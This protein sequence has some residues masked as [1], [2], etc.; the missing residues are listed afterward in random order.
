MGVDV[1]VWGG[2]AQFR[3]RV[4]RASEADPAQ[5]VASFRWYVP[6]LQPRIWRPSVLVTQSPVAASCMRSAGRALG[7]PLRLGFPGMALTP[8]PP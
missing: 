7:L 5:A 8:L 3:D 1:C 2:V 4:L 6:L